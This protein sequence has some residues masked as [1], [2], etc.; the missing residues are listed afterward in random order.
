[1]DAEKEIQDRRPEFAL[2]ARKRDLLMEQM[3]SDA[4]EYDF[5]RFTISDINGV[6]RGRS[7][8]R[9]HVPAFFE[10]GFKVVECKF[11]IWRWLL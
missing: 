6:A 9:K 7:I 8:P 2:Q 3:L 5:V 11:T 10:E 1:M 4:A